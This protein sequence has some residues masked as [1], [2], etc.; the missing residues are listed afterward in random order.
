MLDRVYDVAMSM[1][2]K[3]TAP[4]LKVLSAKMPDKDFIG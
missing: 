4:K 2:D 1:A 3:L